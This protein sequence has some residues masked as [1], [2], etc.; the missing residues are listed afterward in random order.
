VLWVLL[1]EADDVLVDVVP[2]V[3]VVPVDVVPVV[4][5][6]P[7]AGPV[8]GV[9]VE[10]PGSPGPPVHAHATPVPPASEK[11]DARTATELRWILIRGTSLVGYPSRPARTRSTHDRGVG[12]T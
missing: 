6:V 10:L 2:V 4:V 9:P 12:R 8:Q 5:V 11:T 3:V 1:P 7:V